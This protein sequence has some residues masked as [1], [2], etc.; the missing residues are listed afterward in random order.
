VAENDS[1]KNGSGNMK[2]GSGKKVVA[3]AKNGSGS[4]KIW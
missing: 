4:G 2:N 3:V 1:G